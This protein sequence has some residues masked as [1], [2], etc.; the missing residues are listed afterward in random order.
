MGFPRQEYQ[1]GLPFPSLGD[2]PN[3]GIKATPPALASRFFTT[4]PPGKL[5]YSIMVP[6]LDTQAFMQMTFKLLPEIL[7]KKKG[8]P[9]CPSTYNYFIR[10]DFL[11]LFLIH[12]DSL[13][14]LYIYTH[15]YPSL[16][17]FI[18]TEILVVTQLISQVLMNFSFWLAKHC[19]RG[20]LGRAN[21]YLPPEFLEAG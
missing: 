16:V 11:L 2:L 3:P 14:Y 1:C 19:F 15:T 5:H 21:K 8:F 17:Y 12:S 4:D 18:K 6:F 20:N 9:S 10:Q 13:F 7:T